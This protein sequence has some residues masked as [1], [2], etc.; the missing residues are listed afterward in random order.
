M[1]ITGRNGTPLKDKWAAGPQT[2]L[3]VAISEFPNLFLITGPGS[4]SVLS[5]MVISIEQHVE[6]IAD[7][8]AQARALGIASIEPAADVEERWMEN[9]FQ[10]AD[11]NVISQRQLLVSGRQHS[12]QA[13]EL[14]YLSGRRRQISRY[15]RY[16]RGRWL[17]RVSAGRRACAIRTCGFFVASRSGKRRRLGSLSLKAA[18]QI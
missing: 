7:C 18:K 15:L 3:G 4:P 1:D 5:N 9:V 12:G 10:V 13:A 11:G 17:R 2:Y 16:D 6:W 14:S 8:I